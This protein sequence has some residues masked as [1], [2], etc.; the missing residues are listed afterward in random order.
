MEEDYQA[1]LELFEAQD[2][3]R[4]ARRKREREFRLMIQQQ[5]GPYPGLQKATKHFPNTKSTT[6]H[7]PP[8]SG[9]TILQLRQDFANETRIA[10]NEMKRFFFE[11]VRV[12]LP[13]NLRSLS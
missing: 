10:Q 7:E 4:S 13:L 8:D 2:W 9:P 3:I 12:G 5:Q 1:E 6:N 11:Q